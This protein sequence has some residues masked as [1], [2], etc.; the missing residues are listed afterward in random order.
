MEKPRIFLSY[1]KTKSPD[2]HAQ[3]RMLDLVRRSFL[4]RRWEIDDPLQTASIDTI[5]EKVLGALRGADAVVA[6]ATL[7]PPNVMLELGCAIALRIPTCVL[8]NTS[9]LPS[10]ETAMVAESLQP[11]E[12]IARF[13]GLSRNSP[14]PSDI[15]NHEVLPYSAADLEGAALNQFLPR[16]DSAIDR[17]HLKAAPGPRSIRHGLIALG[18]KLNALSQQLKDTPDHPLARFLGGWLG[19]I[20]TDLTR[21]TSNAF[22]VD[23]E[24]YPSCFQALAADDRESADAIADLSELSERS[25][26]LDQ[27]ETSLAVRTRIFLIDGRALFDDA[28]MARVFSALKRQAAYARESHYK[29][30]IA[31]ANHPLWTIRHPFDDAHSCDL[32]TFERGAVAG[33]CTRAG[34]RYLKV[35]SEAAVCDQARSYVEQARRTSFPFDERWTSHVSMR[36]AWFEKD[37]VGWWSDKWTY[38]ERDGHYDTWY[39]YHIRAWIPHYDECVL[40]MSKIVATEVRR[41]SSDSRRSS[42]VLEI[43][44]GTGALTRLLTSALLRRDEFGGR[45]LC[46]PYVAADKSQAMIARIRTDRDLQ[47]LVSNERIVPLNCRVFPDSPDALLRY[48]PFSMIFGSFVLS[49]ILQKNV[50]ANADRMFESCCRL[51]EPGGSICFL[52]SLCSNP[53][54]RQQQEHGWREWMRRSQGLPDRFIKQFFDHNQE[55]L[56]TDLSKLLANLAERHGFEPPVFRTIAGFDDTS[57]FKIL[58]LRRSLGQAGRAEAAR[59]SG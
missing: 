53:Q 46:A 45:D 52:D 30:L 21:G 4:K 42:A 11:L 50:A 32:I 12:V 40:E 22:Y 41:M 9:M 33:Y 56:E 59:A 47:P 38:D 23:D 48:A 58:L 17:I 20:N 15:G 28:F 34:R 57:Q 44:C 5:H 16:L 26:F 54:E 6:D 31:I 18:D 36:A 49:H 10:A 35:S 29:I 24:Y 1:S 3:V 7:C 37:L 8:V 25:L 55:M 43:G 14:L 27:E 19:G 13:F 51:L 39:D 2:S